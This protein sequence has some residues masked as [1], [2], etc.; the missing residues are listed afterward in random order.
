MFLS[1]LASEGRFV[2]SRCAPCRRVAVP[3][4]SRCCRC[5]VECAETVPVG[6][7]GTIVTWTSSPAGLFAL[8]RLDGA[9][10]AL[11]HRIVE[12]S[13]VRTGMRVAAVFEK[14]RKGSI[15]DVAGFRPTGGV[16]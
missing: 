16:R 12:A 14:E 4:T 7:E 8:I 3:P 6:P 10:S 15:L 9:D 2:G 5:H 11:L 1:L 13:E